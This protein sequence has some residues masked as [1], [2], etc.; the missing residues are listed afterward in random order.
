MQLLTDKLSEYVNIIHLTL[1]TRHSQTYL[2]KQDSQYA[3]WSEQLQVP[4]EVFTK[5]IPASASLS[6]TCEEFS[7][8][9]KTILSPIS[10]NLLYFSFMTGN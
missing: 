4:W 10:K 3:H 7:A 6:C 9:S 5:Y 8:T 1:E 2:W